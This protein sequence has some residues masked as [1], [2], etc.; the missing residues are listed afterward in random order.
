MRQDPCIGVLHMLSALD[1][2]LQC[3]HS[4]SI[5]WEISVRPYEPLHA[6]PPHLISEVKAAHPVRSVRHMLKASCRLT[7]LVLL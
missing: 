2:A 4:L 3:L 7:F 5:R 1:K 6:L